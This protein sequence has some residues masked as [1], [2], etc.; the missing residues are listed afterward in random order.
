[1]R[2]SAVEVRI[3][4]LVLRGID[5]RA[6]ERLGHALRDELQRLV[7]EGES[8]RSPPEDATLVQAP[9]VELAASRSPELAGRDIA[10]SVYEGLGR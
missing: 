1:M 10:R 5:V 3:A 2:A 4:Q 7:S 9:G 6:G 8:W